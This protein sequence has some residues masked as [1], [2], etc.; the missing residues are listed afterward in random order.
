MK[1]LAAGLFAVLTLAAPAHAE[2]C[3]AVVC[4]PRTFDFWHVPSA[5]AYHWKSAPWGT[6]VEA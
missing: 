2:E 3:H 1:L 4:A 6:S 5:K